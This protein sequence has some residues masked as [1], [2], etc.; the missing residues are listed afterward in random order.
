MSDEI[1]EARFP[2]RRLEPADAVPLAAIVKRFRRAILARDGEAAARELSEDSLLYW[3]DVRR[4]TVIA[5]PPDS[6]SSRVHTALSLRFTTPEQRAR[7]TGRALFVLATDQGWS[8]PDELRSSSLSARV[9]QVALG[10]ESA[11][12]VLEAQRDRYVVLDFA[13]ERWRLR[14]SSLFSDFDMRAIDHATNAGL[15]EEELV[16]QVAAAIAARVTGGPTTG[17][18]VPAP[19]RSPGTRALFRT[20]EE[21]SEGAMLREALLRAVRSR[22][23]TWLACFE[24]ILCDDPEPP[25]VLVGFDLGAGGATRHV[26]V[27]SIT[28]H[29]REGD[30]IVERAGALDAPLGRCL[31]SVVEGLRVAPELASDRPLQLPFAPDL[32][33]CSGRQR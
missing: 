1:L 12:V 10:R 22:R 33:D 15:S 20:R 3:D 6:V 17:P 7:M 9:E 30:R 29:V 26:R 11:T 13:E 2:G 25:H 8:V 32:V 5:G 18:A 21:P 16:T 31:V 24:P 14:F 23:Q 4:S 27:L 28:R 19:P